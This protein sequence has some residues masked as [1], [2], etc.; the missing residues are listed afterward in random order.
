MSMLL[1][2]FTVTSCVRLKVTCAQV[3]AAKIEARPWCDIS[4]KFKRCRCRCF[5]YQ[6]FEMID[7][8]YCGDKFKSGKFPVTYCDGI[9]GFHNNVWAKE[10]KPKILK[11]ED[12]KA[13]TCKG[14]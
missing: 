14:Y 4:F 12:I 6:E 11:V 7:D 5:D 9:S 10:A 2:I 3:K 1:V 13:N 8:K